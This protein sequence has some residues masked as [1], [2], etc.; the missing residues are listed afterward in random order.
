MESA[1]VRTGL[2]RD[3]RLSAFSSTQQPGYPPRVEEDAASHGP[4]GSSTGGSAEW[5]PHVPASCPP[6]DAADVAGEVALL[7]ATDPPSPTDMECAIDRGSFKG[8]DE[9]LRAAISCAR[10]RG[11]LLQLRSNSKRL[12]NHHVAVADLAPR[13]GKIARTGGP[14]HFSLWLRAGV[15]PTAHTLL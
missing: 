7:V 11:H 4:D 6:P 10:E 15:L 2:A 3:D 13:H 5:P 8:Q 9:C 1:L 12:R 14:G